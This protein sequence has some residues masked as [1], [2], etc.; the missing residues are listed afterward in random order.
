MG[1]PLQGSLRPMRSMR[2]V[3]GAYTLM[4]E[5]LIFLRPG[6]KLVLILGTLFLSA[7]VLMVLLNLLGRYLGRF[8][9]EERQP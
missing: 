8:G 6:L 1:Y 3:G 7:L 5:G 4:L 9:P 2:A